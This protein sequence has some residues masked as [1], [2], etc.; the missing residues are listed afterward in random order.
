MKLV[1][2]DFDGTL[3]DTRPQIEAA[4]DHT[5]RTLGVDPGLREDWLACV[6]L[7]LEEGVRRV[8]VPLG[9]EPEPVLGIYRGF[10]NAGNDHL[11]REF[12]G[13][14][15][16]LEEL[17]RLGV[18]MAIASS[19]RGPLLR[20]QLKALGWEGWFDPIVTPDEVAAAKP[21]P[22]SLHRV[23]AIR[24]LRPE[25]AVMVGDAPF[26]LE[27]AERAGVPSV[28]VG[29]GFASEDALA[30][31]HPRA[32]AADTAALRA[33]LLDMLSASGRCGS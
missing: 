17:R 16:L 19:K 32:Y 20:R 22:E 13:M 23:L 5:L 11:V 25:E 31:W 33:I 12:E 15:G 1:I 9:F 4:I 24:G 6:G 26:D 29:H 2:W 21:D 30:A 27:M 10:V 18:P 7:P 28:A 3:A 8:C 14:A